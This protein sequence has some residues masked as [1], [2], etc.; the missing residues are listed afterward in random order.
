MA[1]P[2]TVSRDP[3]DGDGGPELRVALARA[4]A[5]S[6][7]TASRTA[8]VMASVTALRPVGMR[9]RRP[10][11]ARGASAAFG[12]PAVTASVTATRAATVPAAAPVAPPVMTPARTRRFPTRLAVPVL[13]VMTAVAVL[14]AWATIH[15]AA[16]GLAAGEAAGQ[17]IG[18]PL[19]IPAPRHAGGLPRRFGP[20]TDPAARSIVTEFR[21]RFGAV[22]A[23][24]VADARRA[25]A[26]G[27]RS[28]G[29]DITAAWTSGLY[30]E[31]GRL[32]PQTYRS[33]WIMYLGLD[34]TG[35]LGRPAETVARL[36]MRVLGPYARVGP[37]PVA[38]GHRG[39]SANCTVAWLG[40]T[41][42]AVCGWASG[43]TIGALASPV[44]DT[45]VRELAA[46]MV[47]MR[48]DLQRA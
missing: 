34:A 31:P 29:R 17:R 41:S 43:H 40:Q 13:A 23:G 42:V 5:W 44:R 25:A 38:A 10:G 27:N 30:G 37:W 9:T 48:F 18:G 15:V 2:W 19:V 26:S 12:S 3:Q 4:A 47:R 1:W 33:S 21:Q 36:M 16:R 46:L 14:L 45:S 20:I 32:D 11:P 6:R 39:G 22:G 24:L 8:G 28:P 7:R 35:R